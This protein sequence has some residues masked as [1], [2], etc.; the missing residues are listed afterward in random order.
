MTE[1]IKI[2]SLTSKNVLRLNTVEI[3]PDPEGD[4]IIIGGDNAQGKTS[5]LDSIMLAL[6][7]RKAKHQEPLKRDKKKGEVTV[8]LTNGLIVTRKFTRK[9]NTLTI[10]NEDGEKFTA[11]QQILDKFTSSLTF[12]PL[13]FLEMDKHKQQ[14]TVKD[15]AGL[16]F[17]LLDKEKKDWYETRSDEKKQVKVLEGKIEGIVEHKDVPM[18]E[19]NV[20]EL[21]GELTNAQ[22]HNEMIKDKQSAISQ[23]KISYKLRMESIT[24]N[25]DRIEILLNEIKVLKDANND[26]SA[27]M[28][29][30]KA[31]G[32]TLEAA[33]PEPVDVSPIQTQI[34]TAGETNKK[35]ASNNKL[36]QHKTDIRKLEGSIEDLSDRIQEI[37][38]KKELQIKEASF[39]IEGLGFDEDGITFNKTPFSQSSH[40]E[41]LRIS[42]AMGIS[43][44]PDLKVILIRSGSRLDKNNLKLVAEMASES[45]HQVWIERVGDGDECQVIMEDGYVRE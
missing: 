28:E 36:A 20:A 42:L 8:Q 12:D 10:T 3:T 40:A 11:P 30:I 1:G 29:E 16:D 31:S 5:V 32:K 2:V 17:K 22:D 44:N 41:Q 19:V 6:G 26:H 45:G 25:K 43:L 38:E 23:L 4:L 9:T 15:L 13:S 27:A 39:P 24:D 7:G 14:Q 21:M 34:A 37:D 18:I 33:V 35:I